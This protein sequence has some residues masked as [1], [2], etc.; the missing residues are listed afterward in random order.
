MTIFVIF[1]VFTVIILCDTPYGFIASAQTVLKQY[2][3]RL[4]SVFLKVS[5]SK[6]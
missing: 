1:F 5:E 3:N 4:H 2:H 6:Y